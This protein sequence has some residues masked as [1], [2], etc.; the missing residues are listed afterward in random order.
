MIFRIMLWIVVVVAAFG[1]LLH[2]KFT[3]N[4]KRTNWILA[5]SVPLF[6]LSFYYCGYTFLG[7]NSY[8]G[9]TMGII[10]SLSTLI[11]LKIGKSLKF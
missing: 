4:F 1:V 9:R 3:T 8:S 5:I 11:L 7:W 6:F 2:K 10:S